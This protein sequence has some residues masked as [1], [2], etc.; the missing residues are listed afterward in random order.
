MYVIL[1]HETIKEKVDI[2]SYVEI[3]EVALDWDERERAMYAL[4]A[5]RTTV[6]S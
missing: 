3:G 1:L 4:S 6:D 2:M 5:T